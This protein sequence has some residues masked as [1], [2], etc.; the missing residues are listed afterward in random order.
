[1]II[2]DALDR[3]GCT[4]DNL[5]AREVRTGLPALHEAD[6]SWP[7]FGRELQ[8]RLGMVALQ[9]CRDGRPS[10]EAL[11]ALGAWVVL[12]M[13]ALDTAEVIG[14]TVGTEPGELAA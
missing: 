2:T 8:A 4:T 10:M 11:E 1:M 6:V 14:I 3:I 9:T 7:A 12:S 13:L 5:N